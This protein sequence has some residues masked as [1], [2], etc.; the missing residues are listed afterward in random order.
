M[1]LY[2]RKYRRKNQ[3]RSRKKKKKIVI[4]ILY[5]LKADIRKKRLSFGHCPKGVQ[6]ESKSFK[7]VLLSPILTT[8]WTL[9]F[10]IFIL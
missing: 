2:K 4:K 1:K 7:V 9:P 10:F 6:P 3:I 5:L 8:F